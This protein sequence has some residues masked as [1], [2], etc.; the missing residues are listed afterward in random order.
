M[1]GMF[2]CLVSGRL[3]TTDFTQINEKQVVFNLPDCESIN[4]VVI[5]LTGVQPF[6]DGFGGSVYFC[7]PKMQTSWHL[8]GFISNEKPSAIFKI[9]KVKLLEGGHNPFSEMSNPDDHTMAQIGIS[10]EP[11]SEIANQTP[12]TNSIP[13]GVVSFVE[14]TQ[15]MLHSLFN[16]V[17]SYATTQQ[18]MT[19]NPTE[20]YVPLSV[21]QTWY[22]N[23]ERK[24]AMDPNFWK[25]M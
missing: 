24:L 23:F 17:A 13:S 14:F 19:P 21:L 11:L 22:T 16:F 2:G 8:L 6:P 20:N 1:A 25:A 12:E 9:S 15:K 5:F 3:V 4:H 18:M 7:W 10:L